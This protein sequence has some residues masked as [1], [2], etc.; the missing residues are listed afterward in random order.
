[1]VHLIGSFLIMLSA[2]IFPQTGTHSEESVFHPF[3]VSVTE[4]HYNAENRSLE[5]SVK[6]FTDDL[7]VT[8]NK[9]F[10]KQ[11]D[12]MNPEK[13]DVEEINALLKAY[14]RRH[15]VLIADG[16]RLMFNIVGFE[17]E[18]EA[19][20]SYYEVE[21][22]PPFQ[23]LTVHNAI[24]YDQFKEQINLVHVTNNGKRRSGKV[25]YPKTELKLNFKD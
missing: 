7:E 12:L 23:E 5:I 14:M 15:L 4:I 25:N 3:Y 17:R 21:N 6:I 20:W 22:L 2:L 10:N 24:L 16:K 11:L 8:L 18:K 19:I 1:M 9:A 13:D